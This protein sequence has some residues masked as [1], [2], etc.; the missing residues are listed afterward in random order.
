[1]SNGCQWHKKK[2]SVYQSSSKRPERYAKIF[3]KKSWIQK[4]IEYIRKKLR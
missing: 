4:L 1:M 3:K 2:F